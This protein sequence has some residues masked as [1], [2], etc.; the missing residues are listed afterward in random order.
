MKAIPIEI[1]N[2]GI[3]NPDQKKSGIREKSGMEI[4]TQNMQINLV[5]VTP[6]KQVIWKKWYS[7][8]PYVREAVFA[9]GGCHSFVKLFY[10]HQRF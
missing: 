10:S 9:R 5:S 4:Y 3:A 2:S 8:S 6:E 1:K 7:Y